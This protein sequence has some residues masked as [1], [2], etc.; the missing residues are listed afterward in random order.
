MYN[1][2]FQP[3][4]SI[5]AIK[6]TTEQALKRLNIFCLRDLVFYKP[7]N[8]LISDNSSNL[9]NLKNGTLIQAEVIIQEIIQPRIKHAPVKIYVANKTG[10][11]VLV[12]FNKIPAFIYQKLKLGSKCIISGKVQYF[13][14]SLQITHPEFILKKSLFVPVEPV[15]HLTYGVTNRQLY[16]YIL[17]GLT[18]LEMAINTRLQ[19][20]RKTPDVS[21]IFLDEE[22]YMLS[23]LAQVKQLHLIN[24]VSNPKLIENSL[25]E[26]TCSLAAKELFANQC[27]LARLKRQERQK[28]GRNFILHQDKQSIVHHLGFTLTKSQQEALTEIEQDQTST[29]QMMR[30]LQGDVG[31]GKT[32]VALLTML[33][34]VHSGSQVALMAPTDLLSTQHYSFFLKALDALD[35][36]IALLTGKT[37]AKEKKIIYEQ[38]ANG[39]INILI[40]THALFQENVQF[41][42]LGYIVIDEQHRFGVEQRMDLIA[43]ANSPDVL[44]MTATPIPRSLTLTMFGDMSIS[45]IKEKP[46]NRLPIITSVIS[47]H[48]RAQIILSLQKK[49]DAGEKIYWICPLIDQN[50]EKEK[51]PFSTDVMSVFSELETI[52]AS[53]VGL[54][55]GKIKSADKDKIMSQFKEGSINILVAT[56]V[57]EVGIDVP[58]AT[59]IV[60]DNAEKFGLAQLHQLRGRVGRGSIQS[61]SILIY[62]ANRLSSIAYK[63]L[64]IMKQSNDG[65]YLAEQDLILRG[66]GEILGT[67][68]SGEPEFFFADLGRDAEILF[69]AN[70]LANTI[71]ESE[72]ILFQI[73]LFD[74]QRVNLVKSG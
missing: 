46:Q 32:L 10:S 27:A 69:K 54:L 15:Y 35:L 2:L 18:T 71:S 14:G 66:G 45:L 73:N 34:V 8:Y 25:S 52:Y 70:K 43:K 13:D 9:A 11:L 72:F 61:H 24:H 19:V 53:K 28:A 68:Q 49:I 39:I 20:E 51:D 57:I 63:R 30:L 55:H 3:V 47:H 74:K 29:N 36:N 37:T 6:T 60:I 23:L 12:F 64:E 67:K 16:D 31:S 44:V 42:D 50:E 38:L 1:I 58:D 7:Y 21:H 65:F 26:A 62:N 4:S 56:T 48:K 40:G 59:L 41:K 17:R 33:N 22:K 5:I